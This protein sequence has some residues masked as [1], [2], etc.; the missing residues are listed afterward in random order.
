MPSQAGH[1]CSVGFAI[2]LFIRTFQ[3][4]R[5]P[6]RS[7]GSR[8]SDRGNA[9]RLARQRIEGLRCKVDQWP[10]SVG[11]LRYRRRKRRMK[12]ELVYL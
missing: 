9:L 6:V 4:A 7:A 1:I 5:R 12:G 10:R 11:M 3:A 2:R 8:Q